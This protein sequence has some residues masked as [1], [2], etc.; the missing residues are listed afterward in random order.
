MPDPFG[1]A[2]LRAATLDAWRTS[3]TR[4]TEDRTA[5]T[6]LVTVGYRDRLFTELVANAAD[7]AAAAHI[8][9]DVAIWLDGVDPDP[10][11]ADTAEVD[12][13]AG[14]RLHVANTGVPL[15][16]EGVRSLVAMRVSAKTG[17]TGS[18]ARADTPLVGHFGVGFTATATIARRVEIRSATGSIAF[19]RAAAADAARGIGHDAAVPLLRLAWPIDTPP[20]HGY[21]TEIVLYLDPALITSG[22]GPRR[23]LDDA[24]GQAVDLLTELPPLQRITVAD[25][26]FEI[27][28]RPLEVAGAA[29]DA[30]I[31]ELDVTATGGRAAATDGSTAMT[32]HWLQACRGDTRWLVAHDGDS[33]IIPDGDVLRAPTPTDIELSLPARCI[34]R[35]P[36]TP[37]RRHLHPD[38]DIDSAAAGYADLM[39]AVDP[40][41]RLR[42][43]PGP[44][45]AR[46]ATDARLID[47]VLAELRDA[48]WLPGAADG[49]AGSGHTDLVPSRAHVL[50]GLTGELAD[51]LGD[52]F[53]DLVHPDLSL[54]H[55][56]PALERLGVRRIGL[57]GLAERLAGVDRPPSWWQRLYG[58]LAPLVGTAADAEELATLPV[59]R[60]DGRMNIGVRGLFSAGRVTAPM[61]WLPTV[62][63]EA[64]HPLLERLGLWRIEVG[65][66]LADPALRALVEEE[67]EGA[68]LDDPPV[69]DAENAGDDEPDTAVP[70]LAGEVIALLH[71]DPDAAV[72]AWLSLLPLPDDR[73]EL[74]SADELLLPDA[75]LTGVLVEDHPFGLVDPALADRAG[76]DTLRRIGVGWGFTTVADDLPVAPDHEL[77]DEEDWWDTLPE[78]PERL[79]A[80]RDLDL[81]DERRW[82]GALTLLAAD[83]AIAPLLADRNGYTGWWLRHFAEIDGRPLGELRAPSD[84]GLA[85]VLDP[86]D[87]P[88][89]DDLAGALASA[90]PDGADAATLLLA[91][92][93]DAARDIEPGVAARVYAAIV[94]A[95]R[96]GVV[97]PDAIEPPD[98]VRSLAGT[99]VRDAVVPDAPWWLQALAD[100]E[101]IPPGFEATGSQGTGAQGAG[102]PGVADV[103]AELAR[104][105]DVPTAGEAWS[106]RVRDAGKAVPGSSAAATWFAALRGAAP[107]HGDIRMHDELWITVRRNT[108]A[109]IGADSG[110]G[111]GAEADMGREVRV[112]W[113]VDGRG[114]THVDRPSLHGVADAPESR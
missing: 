90:I 40:V 5:E 55:H 87:H 34:T 65:A 9:G 36:L 81:V 79:V 27:D 59:P 46:G 35:L 62:A 47:A 1:T 108:D 105:L 109:V 49:D 67:S 104:I 32:S 6:D 91:R 106:A 114:V 76:A 94:D 33:L 83:P 17:I 8:D 15:T 12:R 103:A 10:D 70:G 7:A 41:E 75:P 25:R 42:L 53:T 2:A 74:R 102:V 78:P 72:P 107:I 23:I 39:L 112:A 38:A 43:V 60:A 57:A 3:P 89:A 98:A 44:H 37:D 101:V 73:G 26:T 64:D 100:D 61:R 16:A 30:S 11:R 24:R 99:A 110:G 50:I 29:P 21:D 69:G 77:P 48:A 13:P 51:V 14:P 97:D 68:G 56:L 82:P 4:L 22:G 88:H 86:L 96:R 58:A 85:G 45:N 54:T 93:G 20:R 95:V 19:D 63:A 28:R 111:A 18:G 113:W 80:V 84:G 66:A 52:L 92:L 71:A 31:G